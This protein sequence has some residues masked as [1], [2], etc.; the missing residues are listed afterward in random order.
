MK[1][2]LRFTSLLLAVVLLAA[3]I[4]PAS[5][6]GAGQSWET[7]VLF[8]HDL[9]SHFFPQADGTGGESGGYA[10]LMTALERQRAQHPDALTVDGGDF[11]IGSLIQTLYTTQAAELRTMGAMGYDAVTAGNHEFD[12]EGT[13]FARMLQSAALSGD[14]LPALLMA[15]YKPARDNPDQLDI[16]RAMAAY[17]VQETLLLERGGVT[18]GIFGLMGTESHSMA[19]ASGFA[20]EDPAQAAQ[21]CVEALREQGADFIICLSH[22]GTNEKKS[23]SED[24][25]LAEAV[26][27]I[28]LIVSGHTHTTLTEPIVSGDTYI[29]SAGPYCQNLGSIT[30]RWNAEGEKTLVDYQLIPIDETLPEDPEIQAL[31]DGWKAQVDASYLSAYGLTYDQVLTTS[32]FNLDTPPAGIQ[33]GNGLGEL[34]A[35]SYLWAVSNLEAE[36]PEAETV[37]VTAAGVLRAPLYS[38]DVTVSQA[39]DVLS[40]GVGADGTSGYPLVGVYLTGKELRAV[41]EVDASVTPIMPEAQLYLSGIAYSFNTHRM[42]FN[43]VTQAALQAPAFAGGSAGPVRIEDDRLY[44][45]VTGMY[46]AQMLGTVK[47][48]SFGLLN[49]QPKDEN[50]QPVTDFTQYILRDKN[51]NEIKEW[52]ALASYLASFG[53]DGLPDSYAFS[54]GR[55][56]VSR[57]WNPIE[58]LKRPNWITLAVVLVLVLAV[59]LVVFLVRHIRAGR[60]RRRYGGGYRN[61]RWFGR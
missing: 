25:Q 17:G 41:L 31:A 36:A 10:R 12:H 38:G 9:H 27:G 60:R 7:T 42:F 43:R 26:E 56:D 23:L 5:A 52:Y 29:V 37:A 4:L 21:R 51:G 11:S 14:A 33:Q 19:P 20:L 16:Q 45:V 1:H 6:D 39:F 49:I 58:L 54:D 28:D 8:T 59:V 57:S 55:K 22:S 3:L 15:N 61:R 44:R 18:Y 13:G 47:E 50:G 34:A 32:G 24:E 46:S 30:L 35:D 53:E 2:L 40:M 48:K